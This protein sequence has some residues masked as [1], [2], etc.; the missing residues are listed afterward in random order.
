[1]WFYKTGG[2]AVSDNGESSIY[3]ACAVHNEHL[4][5]INCVNNMQDTRRQIRQLFFMSTARL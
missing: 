4:K 1:M 2:F 3:T 5:P